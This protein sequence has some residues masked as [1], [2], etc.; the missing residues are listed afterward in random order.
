MIAIKQNSAGHLLIPVTVN[1]IE[2]LFIL[3]ILGQVDL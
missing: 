3:E 2:G 1:G